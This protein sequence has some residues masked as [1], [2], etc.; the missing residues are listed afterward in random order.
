ML[1]TA[2]RSAPSPLRRPVSLGLEIGRE[3]VSGERW[4]DSARDL[5]S[6]W[7]DA[8]ATHR[9]LARPVIACL[10][11]AHP[12]RELFVSLTARALR[13][14][15]VATARAG[16]LAATVFRN[17]LRT[18]FVDRLL[19]L[20]P[21]GVETAIDASALDTIAPGCVLATFHLQGYPLLPAA[22]AQRGIDALFLRARRE[23]LEAPSSRVLYATDAATPLQLV[24]A[25][26]TGRHAVVMTDPTDGLGRTTQVRLFG[27][28]VAIN[29]GAAWLATRAEVPLVPIVIDDVGGRAVVRALPPIAAGA[30]LQATLQSVTRA[31]ELAVFD[32]PDTWLLWYAWL[33]G[34]EASGLRQRLRTSHEA[35]WR[36][37]VAS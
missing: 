16:T 32:A 22:L 15:G 2:K 26:R 28:D 7:T 37:L 34:D 17:H 20:R 33:G 8:P 13:Q 11:Q 23:P 6:R 25:V 14:A 31:L 27:R 3:R 30:D 18:Q 36:R 24:R 29:V 35:I 5:V 4:I 21:A 19:A 12:D 9:E 10:E 1:R